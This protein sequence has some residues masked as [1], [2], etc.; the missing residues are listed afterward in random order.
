[1]NTRALCSDGTLSGSGAATS[2][3]ALAA[4]VV[5]QLA[6]WWW[7]DR[8]TALIVGA[9]AA[10]DARMRTTFPAQARRPTGVLSWC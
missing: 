2:F 7:T 1:M 5:D 3:L 8:I 6:G 9:V 4:L 10:T